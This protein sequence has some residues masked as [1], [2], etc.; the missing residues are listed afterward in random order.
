MFTKILRMVMRFEAN[1]NGHCV[2]DDSPTRSG[3]CY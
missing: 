1:M 2:G 3:H